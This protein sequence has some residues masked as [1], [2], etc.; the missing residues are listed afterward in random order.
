MSRPHGSDAN[1]GTLQR[2]L[3]T[4]EKARDLLRAH[5]DARPATVHLRAG[6]YPLREG[7]ALTA[8]DSGTASAP[9]VYRGLPERRGS[10][11]GRSN[12]R[13]LRLHSR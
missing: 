3:A 2:P 4:V 7:L 1:P 13:R 10:P 5:Q 8:E 9:I 12:G 6:V 11:G